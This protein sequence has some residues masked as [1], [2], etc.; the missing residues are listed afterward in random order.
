MSDAMPQEA[1]IE[2]SPENNGIIIVRCLS[3]YGDT[4]VFSLPM[5]FLYP[6]TLGL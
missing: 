3:F 4:P 6:V 1:T 2:D 5:F